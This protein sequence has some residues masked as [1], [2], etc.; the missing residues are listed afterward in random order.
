MDY[1]MKDIKLLFKKYI[2]KNITNRLE[3][4]A[5]V[6][7][8]NQSVLHSK[9]L[10]IT[11]DLYG[12]NELII[13]LT[14]YNK[15]LYE[16]YLTIETIMQQTM[17]PN[18]IVLWLED[19]LKS[20][21]IPLALQKQEERGLEIKYCEDTKSYNKLIPSLQQYPE[22]IIVTIDDDVLYNFD[23]LENLYNSYKNEPS[24]IHTLRMHR[25]K[26]RSPDRLEQYSKWN[27]N[28]ENFDVSPLNFPTGIGGV[29]YPPHCFNQEV[30]NKNVFMNICKYADDIWFKAMSLLNGVIS[31][32][33]YTH[34]KNGKNYLIN[35]NVQDITLAKYNN[36]KSM[37]DIQLKAVFDKYNLY[38]YLD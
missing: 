31:Q 27:W 36:D 32:K 12:T 17:K 20:I 33:A 38:H 35:D 37:N 24:R 7:Y 19:D 34:N 18:K 4:C 11:S 30:L 3:Y 28:Y 25:I 23:I 2:D 29:L 6:Q 1:I 10:G 8:L 14:T 9:E 16:V 5:K 26:L 22:S 21:P 13:S 15:R